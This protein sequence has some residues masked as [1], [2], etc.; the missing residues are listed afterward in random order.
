MPTWQLRKQ[1]DQHRKLGRN[2]EV[3]TAQNMEESG[4]KL[5]LKCTW[6]PSIHYKSY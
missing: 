1:G 3:I 2:R 4:G 5:S 6:K